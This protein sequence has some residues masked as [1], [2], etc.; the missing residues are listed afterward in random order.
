MQKSINK[1]SF[2]L[3][4]PKPVLRTIIIRTPSGN[5]MGCIYLSIFDLT[6]QILMFMKSKTGN[7]PPELS[8]IKTWIY[9]ETERVNIE[10]KMSETINSLLK[11]IQL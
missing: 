7:L 9:L 6:G 8:K 11:T 10:N 3:S 5:W 2:T 4:S 1:K